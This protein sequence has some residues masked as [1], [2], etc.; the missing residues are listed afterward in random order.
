MKFGKTMDVDDPNVDIEGGSKVK[1]T[2]SEKHNFRSK[3]KVTRSMQKYD[4]RSHLPVL[5]VML[6]SWVRVKVTWVKVKGQLG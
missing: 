4:F 6:R 1:V 5:Q 2:R 3:V